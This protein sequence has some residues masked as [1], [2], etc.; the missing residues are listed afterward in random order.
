VIQRG[1]GWLKGRDLVLENV[2]WAPVYLK[3]SPQPKTQY[4]MRLSEDGNVLQ[5][6]AVVNGRKGPILTWARDE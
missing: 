4:Y 5:G 3:G 2:V 6:Y 1:E